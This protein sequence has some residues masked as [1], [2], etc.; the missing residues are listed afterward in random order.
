MVCNQTLITVV[1]RRRMQNQRIVAGLDIG[2]TKI[3]VIVGRM[4]EYEKLEVL[5]IGQAI[6]EGVKEGI[7]SNIN[8]TVAA[9]TQAVEEAERNSGVNLRIVNVGIAGKHIKSSV[10]HGSITRS[11]KME[12]LRLL[13]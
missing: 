3:C 4:N 13:M 11:S 5:G 1:H 10:H 12:K 8:K 2:T 6:S 7:I 9:I